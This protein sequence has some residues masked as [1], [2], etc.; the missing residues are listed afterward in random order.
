MDENSEFLHLIYLH[1]KC[2]WSLTTHFKHCL[3]SLIS[4]PKLHLLTQIWFAFDQSWLIAKNRLR[5]KRQG[6]RNFSSTNVHVSSGESFPGSQWAALPACGRPHFHPIPTR[7]PRPDS[8]RYCPDAAVCLSDIVR[9]TKTER[10]RQRQ[11]QR[12]THP[13]PRPTTRQPSLLPWCRSC[14]LPVCLEHF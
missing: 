12:Q 11:I 10:E 4:T 6:G 9:H 14:S 7:D 8:H 13:H 3:K 2:Y 5:I 1:L